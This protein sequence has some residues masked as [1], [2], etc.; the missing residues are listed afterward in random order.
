MA[1][2]RD[3]VQPIQNPSAPQSPPLPPFFQGIQTL[4]G[5]VQDVLGQ[6]GPILGFI[7]GP[8]GDLSGAPT[9]RLRPLSEKARI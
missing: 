9:G 7:P 1:N 4:M 2:I 5:N 6:L 3:T 8:V